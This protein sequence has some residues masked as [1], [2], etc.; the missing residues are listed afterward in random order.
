MGEEGKKEKKKRLNHRMGS[1]LIQDSSVDGHN[2]GKGGDQSPAD[3][4]EQ[5]AS[6]M[7]GDCSEWAAS[8]AG[9]QQAGARKGCGYGWRAAKSRNWA[10]CYDQEQ[11][12]SEGAWQGRARRQG[13]ENKQQTSSRGDRGRAL[14]RRAEQG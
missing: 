4:S 6:K 9:K 1:I 5:G 2:N 8:H 11:Y 7:E 12:K 3:V 10:R 13:E 14:G